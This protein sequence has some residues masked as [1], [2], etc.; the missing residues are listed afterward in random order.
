MAGREI[1]SLDE[2]KALLAEVKNTIVTKTINNQL[3]YIN[4]LKDPG[5]AKYNTLELMQIMSCLSNVLK[6]NVQATF[7]SN[8]TFTPTANAQIENTF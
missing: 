5:F 8:T 7:N 4:K 3:V 1:K 2:V 6:N